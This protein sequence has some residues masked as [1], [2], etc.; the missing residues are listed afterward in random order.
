MEVYKYDFESRH[1]FIDFVKTTC[2]H[3]NLIVKF[4]ADWC[5][6]CKKIYD[7]C[8][9]Q[10]NSYDPKQVCCIEVNIDDSFDIY[11]FLKQRKMIQGIPTLY[12]YRRGKDNYIPDE[13]IS[14]TDINDLNYFFINV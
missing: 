12:L 14:G 4:S 10:F 9:E 3:R 8:V 5:G 7:Y 11:A 1:D 6:P 2:V 13:S